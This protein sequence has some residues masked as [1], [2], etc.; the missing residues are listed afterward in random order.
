MLTSVNPRLNSLL[1]QGRL[2]DDKFTLT[3]RDIAK[4]VASDFSK[5]TFLDD[6]SCFELHVNGTFTYLSVVDGLIVNAVRVP[7][8]T[9]PTDADVRVKEVCGF[10]LKKLEE[11]PFRVKLVQLVFDEIDQM[12]TSAVEFYD[13]SAHL[14]AWSCG[15]VSDTYNHVLRMCT[16]ADCVYETAG[17]PYQE[18]T[19]ENI[20]KAKQY[21]NSLF[22]N[23]DR[24]ECLL[25]LISSMYVDSSI[26]DYDDVTTVVLLGNGSNGKTL[27]LR[28]IRAMFGD[29]INRCRVGKERMGDLITIMDCNRM[30]DFNRMPAFK[31]APLG[32]IKHTMVIPFEFT[33]SDDIKGADVHAIDPSLEKTLFTPGMIAAMHHIVIQAG[34]C[35]DFAVF[36]PTVSWMDTI[37]ALQN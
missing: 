37:E 36:R 13:R 14:F 25:S 29:Y 16:P 4:W 20:K 31:A 32:T 30:S 6:G 33:F 1:Q 34:E 12:R 28:V 35:N 23:P 21:T 2:A 7:F 3:T 27:L 15:T 9:C 5:H 10:V 19:I 22:S 24:V 17:Y 8:L 11:E 26:G 18:A